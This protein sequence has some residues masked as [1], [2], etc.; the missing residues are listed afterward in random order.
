[1]LSDNLLGN[2]SGQ[3]WP[4]LVFTDK[5]FY[6]WILIGFLYCICFV[7]KSQFSLSTGFFGLFNCYFDWYVNIHSSGIPVSMNALW[8][9]P[10]GGV[11]RCTEQKHRVN[12]SE[13]TPYL[14]LKSSHSKRNPFFERQ[15]SL[16]YQRRRKTERGLNWNC[17][18]RN[19][20]WWDSVDGAGFK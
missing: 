14:L 15:K 4:P 13:R 11:I 17:A 10:G 20:K 8:Y 5:V 12:S 3:S 7:L 9:R 16:M 6:P 1:M 19:R 18:T 2:C